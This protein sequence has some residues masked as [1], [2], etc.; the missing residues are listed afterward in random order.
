MKFTL[1]WL[2]HHLETDASVDLIAET[3]TDLGLEVEGVENPAERLADFTIGY[4]Q[5]AEKHPDADKL[6][7][8][9]VDLGKSGGV[10]QIVCGA[11]NVDAGQRVDQVGQVRLPRRPSPPLSTS[12][13]TFP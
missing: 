5:S 10:V 2:K 6:S 12:P 11:P 7:V 13:L 4:V 3:L 9:Q 1:S 8:C